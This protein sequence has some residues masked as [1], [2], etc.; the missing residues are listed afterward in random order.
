MRSTTHSTGLAEVL[1]LPA[2]LDRRLHWRRAYRALRTVIADPERTDQ[3]IE[4]INS[5]GGN[6]DLRAFAR[7]RAHPE[8]QA[9]LAEQPSLLATLADLDRLAALPDDTFG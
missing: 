3:V 8:G 2:P 1:R 5:L 6:A 7:F 9:L 4:L